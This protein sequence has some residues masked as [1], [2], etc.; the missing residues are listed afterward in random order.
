MSAE[1]PIKPPKSPCIDVCVLHRREGICVGCLRTGEEI[2]AWPGMSDAERERVLA[3]LPAR[4]PRLRVR[5][6]GRG[7]R[8][9]DP[10]A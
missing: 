7:T 10:G 9:R 1:M 3:E 5:R 4:A 6:G 2:A 8:G